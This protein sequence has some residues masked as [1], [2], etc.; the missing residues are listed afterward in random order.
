[1][2]P[3]PHAIAPAV[4]AENS[5]GD[6]NSSASF[7]TLGRSLA[8]RSEH[9]LPSMPAVEPRPSRSGSRYAGLRH[10]DAVRP[11][12]GRVDSTESLAGC[13]EQQQSV[14]RL[15]CTTHFENPV[16]SR[17]RLTSRDR[18]GAGE[19][20]DSH[21]PCPLPD[22]RG[23]FPR[24][25]IRKLCRAPKRLRADVTRFTELVDA[26]TDNTHNLFTSLWNRRCGTSPL[27][28]ASNGGRAR[29][30]HDEHRTIPAYRMAKLPQ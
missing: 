13:Q 25:L 7:P 30:W 3:E 18:E 19:R 28:R 11:N 21:P 20:I 14:K 1:M 16:G 29:Q 27:K 26:T 2:D 23:S 8:R 5:A 15:R 24:P 12:R 9:T 10:G 6:R 17:L 22:G 4:A